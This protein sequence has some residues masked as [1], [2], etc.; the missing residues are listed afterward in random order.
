MDSYRGFPFNIREKHL[1]MTLLAAPFIMA[2]IML[3]LRNLM[4]TKTLVITILIS[5]ASYYVTI[6]LIPKLKGYMVTAGIT[7]K[8]IHKT[9]SLE[10]KKPIPEAMG[11]VSSLIFLLCSIAIVG[12]LDHDKD[13]ILLFMSGLLTIALMIILGF[14]DDVVALKWKYKLVLPFAASF[15]LL[16]VYDG[17]SIIV[18]PSFVRFIL[19]KYLD[20]GI[21]YKIY[22]VALTIFCTNSINIHA[23]VNGLEIGQSLVIAAF[24][25]MY[26]VA[27]VSWNEDQQQYE[28]HLFSLVMMIP[29]IFTSLALY[30]YNRFP[31]KVFVGDTYTSFAGIVFAV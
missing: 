18:L 24:I 5:V 31:S 1:A 17:S 26:N 9:G 2:L 30:K 25:I 8:D 16:I 12:L 27:K 3:P 21:F 4:L 28:D 13:K 14:I 22:F 6:D 7:G 11:I 29:F 23:G 19:G 15:A 20:I 10:S